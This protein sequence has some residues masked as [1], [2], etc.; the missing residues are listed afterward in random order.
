[1]TTT[2]P[3]ADVPIRSADE[4]T[5]R[6]TVLLDPPIFG[7]RSL[8][9]TWLDAEGRMLPILMPIDDIPRNPDA[10]LL[11][12][13]RRVHIGVAASHLPDGGHFAIALCRPGGP[14]VT[15]DDDVWA[16]A[17]CEALDGMPQPY[18]SLHLATGGTIVPL[19]NLPA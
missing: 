5:Q 14:E 11:E 4:L 8:V 6:W 2:P 9:L 1:M 12:G 16:E 7:A 10:E 19:V 13:L 17:L 15:R 3:L 18:W